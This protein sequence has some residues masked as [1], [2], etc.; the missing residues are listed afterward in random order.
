ML[1]PGRRRPAAGLARAVALGAAAA[2]LLGAACSQKEGWIGRRKKAYEAVAAVVSGPLD[3]L[4]PFHE[5]ITPGPGEDILWLDPRWEACLEAAPKVAELERLAIP[6]DENGKPFESA[7]R[8]RRAA[9]RF[10]E[11]VEACRPG[12]G[13]TR[14]T[15]PACALQCTR[16]WAALTEAA[17]YLYEDA[18]WVEVRITPIAPPPPK[19]AG[20][21]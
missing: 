4:R 15:T 6:P 2:A 19:A 9:I 7:E 21:R 8:L 1:P 3:A 20:R 17:Q 13:G 18:E 10:R 12:D 5:R 11:G 14:T 16:T